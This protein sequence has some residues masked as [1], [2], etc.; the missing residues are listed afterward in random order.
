MRR[1]LP[2]LILLIPAVFIL[3]YF[4]KAYELFSKSYY[5]EETKL[6]K[7]DT[8]HLFTRAFESSDLGGRGSSK[9]KLVFESANKYSFVIDGNFYAAITDRKKLE[10]TLMYH[11]TKFTVFTDKKNYD[12]YKKSKKPIFIK[13]YQ[14]QIGD[15]KYI[16]IQKLN[17]IS[18]ENLL[19]GVVIP[20]IIIMF[21]LFLVGKKI[22]WYTSLKI[23]L[24]G[25]ALILTIA[26][27]AIIIGKITY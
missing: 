3:F 4:V 6:Y 22:E 16:D 23:I 27:F 17:K 19:G 7:T 20:L 11:D 5:V 25:I 15:T 2:F 24:W 26:G 9:P 10:D 1:K 8:F 12:E 21:V 14:I 13:V 18:K